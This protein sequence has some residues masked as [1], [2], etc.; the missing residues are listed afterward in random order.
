M[1]DMKKAPFNLN[2]EQIKWVEEIKGSFTNEEKIGQLFFLAGFAPSEEA[3][4]QMLDVF[5]QPGGLMYRPFPQEVVSKAHEKIQSKFKAPLFLAAN[6]EAGGNGLILEGTHV[7]P[8]MQCAATGSSEYA[9]KQAEVAAKELK[10]VGGNMSFAPVIDINFNANNPITNTRAYSDRPDFVKECSVQATKAKQLNGVAACI[11]HYPGD[12]HDDRDHHVLV[13]QNNLT[14]SE[15]LKTYGEVYRGCIEEGALSLMVGHIA[16]P[17]YYEEKHPDVKNPEKIPA[18]LSKELLNDV[19]R[20]ELGFNGLTM[21]D[22]TMMV[23]FTANHTRKE[24][25]VRAFNAGCDMI[26]FARNPIEDYNSMLNSFNA[27]EIS[28]ERL[29]EAITRILATKAALNLHDKSSMT[30]DGACVGSD[31]HIK[32]AS[33]IA[34]KSITLVKNEDN[35]LPLKPGSRIGVIVGGSEAGLFAPA[36]EHNTFVKELSNAGFQAEEIKF[37]SMEDMFGFGMGGV[38]ALKAKYDYIIY[39]AYFSPASNASNLRFE[40]KA[41]GFDAPWFV[42]DLPTLFV[43]FGNPYHHHDAD[44]VGTF[45]NAYSPSEITTKAVV[46]KLQGKTEFVGVSPVDPFNH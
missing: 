45:I 37:Q 2:D 25:L 39:A 1:I 15:W 17:K 8:N 7:G 6:T 27:G 36:P 41:L 19:L 24:A 43:S 4:F 29:D 18:S 26:L 31:E 42:K 9:Y 34:D 21:T 10:S 35:Y 5:K 13:S 33:E 38:D 16:L 23:G 20:G 32:V 44:C 40:Y 11:K 12:G 22:A 46:D 28:Q 30:F 14:Y 3:L